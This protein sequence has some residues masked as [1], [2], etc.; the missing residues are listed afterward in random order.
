[1]LAKPL[2]LYLLG[3]SEA[4]HLGISV[5]QLKLRVITCVALLVGTSV[6][7]GGMIG[8]I[9]LVIPHILRLLIGPDHR[10]LLPAS[11]L[12]GASVL[13]LADLV[14]RLILAPAEL[15]IGLVTSA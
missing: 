2:N 3:E 10:R 12:L 11:A 8:F 6:A 9:G 15:P 7:L 14:S 13:L 5:Q 4:G 1:R